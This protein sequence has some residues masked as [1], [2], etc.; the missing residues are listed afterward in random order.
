[1][2]SIRCDACRKDIRD[3]RKDVNYSV[4]LGRDLCTPCN[5][6]LYESVGKAWSGRKPMRFGEYQGLL[7]KAVVKM[8]G[9]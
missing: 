4:I 8:T 1:M 9:G 5:E 7:Q 6:K 2:T 3:A